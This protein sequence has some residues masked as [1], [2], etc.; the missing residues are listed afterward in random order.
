MKDFAE[1]T[2]ATA[3]YDEGARDKVMY[4]DDEELV[5]LLKLNYLTNGLASEAGEVAGVMKKYI[6]GD[7]DKD[8]MIRRLRKESADTLW[9]IGRIFDDLG[10]DMDLEAEML[11][12]HLL[13]RDN[14]GVIRGD[15]DER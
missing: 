5:E 11:L 15:G 10:L 3:K 7:Y 4:A 2:R 1:R 9:Y 6:R 14:K 8:E 12:A 13:D